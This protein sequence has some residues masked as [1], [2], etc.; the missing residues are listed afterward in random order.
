MVVG[1]PR[2]DERPAPVQHLG[3]RTLVELLQLVFDGTVPSRS[4]S[5][6]TFDRRARGASVDALLCAFLQQLP[7]QKVQVLPEQ[8]TLAPELLQLTAIPLLHAVPRFAST[9]LSS[10]ADISDVRSAGAATV[11]VTKASVV[12]TAA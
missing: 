2:P 11:R 5:C 12:Q 6:A 7:Q 3:R 1:R 9:F 10:L 8:L 4:A